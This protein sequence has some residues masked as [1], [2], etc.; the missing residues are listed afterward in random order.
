[1]MFDKVFEYL[2]LDSY[3]QVYPQ[4]NLTDY[5]IRHSRSGALW[6]IVE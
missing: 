1:M 6:R 4:I 3:P 2:D 5:I